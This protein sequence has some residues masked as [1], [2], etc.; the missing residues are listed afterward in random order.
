MEKG[1]FFDG[2]YVDGAGVPVY[3]GVK[4]PLSV[5]AYLAV[6]PATRRNR[7]A[8]GAQKALNL[9]VSQGFEK[10]RRPRLNQS[11]LTFQPGIVSRSGLSGQRQGSRRESQGTKALTAGRHELTS[12]K[13]MRSHYRIPSYHHGSKNKIK[14]CHSV[15]A[16]RIRCYDSVQRS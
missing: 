15:D 10:G 1:L 7:A 6:A 11:P 2:V 3:E 4:P 12:R 16:L 8:A 13:P 14:R 5:F 9:L